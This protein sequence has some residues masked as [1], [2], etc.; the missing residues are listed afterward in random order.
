MFWLTPVI[1]ST[2]LMLLPSASI[3]ITCHFLVGYKVVR[4]SRL[5]LRFR[6]V[7]PR[8]YCCP[9][10]FARAGFR[11]ATSSLPT[12]PTEGL[13]VLVGF[14]LVFHGANIR[15]RLRICKDYFLS[16]LFGTL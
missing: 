11:F 12:K 15:K 16:M 9:C 5:L 10:L 8:H 2:A 1:R 6:L 13:R 4:H 3:E 14:L 7:P